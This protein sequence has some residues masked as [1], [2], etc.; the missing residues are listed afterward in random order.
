[1]DRDG[2]IKVNRE[3]TI[4]RHGSDAG[5]K[6]GKVKWERNADGDWQ[7]SQME[8]FRISVIDKKLA[9]TGSNIKSPHTLGPRAAR[10]DPKV[11]G[12]ADEALAF[13][14]K[15]YS[16][17]RL[18]PQGR[19]HSS[20]RSAPEMMYGDTRAE[21]LE[22]GKIT[23][24]EAAGKVGEPVGGDKNGVG[25]KYIRKEAFTD[26]KIDFYDAT[27]SVTAHIGV[28]TGDRKSL[29]MSKLLPS[30]GLPAHH[31][32]AT[33][34]LGV[35]ESKSGSPY[36]SVLSGSKGS[37]TDADFKGFDEKK[38]SIKEIA[39]SIWTPGSYGSAPNMAGYSSM[40]VKVTEGLVKGGMKPELAKQ[41]AQKMLNNFKET[42]L[43][44][45]SKGFTKIIGEAPENFVY[46]NPM[47]GYRMSFNKHNT[48]K[49]Y[50]TL[51]TN[52]R[53]SGSSSSQN[54]AVKL[55]ADVP[56]TTNSRKTRSGAA[57]LFVQN[58]DSAVMSDLMLKQRSPY[59]VHDAIGV[60]K[61]MVGRLNANVAKS[62]MTAQKYKPLEDLSNQ[63]M[64][65]H[66]KNGASPTFL[67]K[68]RKDL[69]LAIQQIRKSDEQFTFSAQNNHFALE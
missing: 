20:D 65:Q 31:T 5:V 50:L 57:A 45:F 8:T 68:T 9:A 46:E 52:R 10:F 53:S 32:L 39:K 69:D 54:E 35:S 47:S 56:T 16:D 13:R 41:T 6:V 26:R 11:G 18:A 51:G 44:K 19:Y 42:S 28:M 43:A 34:R 30:K 38:A 66:E 27:S 24:K 48:E 25:G 21:L 4:M 3:T 36:F 63:I 1:M 67:A 23:P 55:R 49:V 29:E 59:T 2:Q 14:R 37:L 40:G 62:M 7:V 60:K 12:Q 33:K 17:T 15:E 22:K 58:W 64:K 61:S